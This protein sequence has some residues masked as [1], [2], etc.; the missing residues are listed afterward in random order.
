MKMEHIVKKSDCYISKFLFE[1]GGD[2]LGR[3]FDC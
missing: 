2:R 1:V 3:I